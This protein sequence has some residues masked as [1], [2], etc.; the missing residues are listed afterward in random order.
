MRD[1]LRKQCR[2]VIEEAWPAQ[3]RVEVNEVVGP[4]VQAF[5]ERVVAF[6]PPTRSLA[7][8]HAETLRQ[9]NVFLELRR[10]RINSVTTGLPA[11]LWYVVIWG[12]SAISCSAFCFRS[13][14]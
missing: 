7:N 12:R 9:L 13:I 10:V 5:T 3:R 4:I 1:L 2:F 6:D 8:L 14:G 11:T